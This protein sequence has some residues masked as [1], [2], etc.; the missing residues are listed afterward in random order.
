MNDLATRTSDVLSKPE[1]I[2]IIRSNIASGGSLID[3]CRDW[4]VRYCDVD[5]W[6]RADALRS[7]MYDDA[8]KAREEW[9]IQKVLAIA[10]DVSVVDPADLFRSDGCVKDIEDIPIAARMAITG[11]DIQETFDDDGKKTGVIKKIRLADRLKSA[12][13]LGKYLFMFIERKV[14]DVNINMSQRLS[15]ARKR[16]AEVTDAIVV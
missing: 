2:E 1:T 12:E 13:M 14:V 7:K 5:A 6:I 4:Q 9:F 16:A 3:L 10:R 8:L 11:I 15:E